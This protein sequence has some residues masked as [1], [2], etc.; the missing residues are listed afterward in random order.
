MSALGPGSTSL[1][2]AAYRYDAASRL[3]GVSDGT[4]SA[5]YTHLANSPMVGQIMFQQNG[6]TRMT[7]QKTYDYVNRLTS[8]ASMNAQASTL[9]SFQFQNNSASQRTNV[10]AADGSYWV[11]QYDALGQ[12]ISGKRYWSDGTIVAGEQFTYER[13]KPGKLKE[14][15]T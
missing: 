3:Y 14:C 13:V 9:S 15:L 7:T 4:N 6:A 10:L 5:S 8:T 12:V 11:Y 2:T 1:A